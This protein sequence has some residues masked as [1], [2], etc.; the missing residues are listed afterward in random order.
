MDLI[1]ELKGHSGSTV[2]LMRDGGKT[3]VRKIDNVQRNYERLI[4]LNAKLPVPRIYRYDGKI[5]DMEY[6]HGL[7]MKNYLLHHSAK[8]LI[9]FL[10]ESIEWMKRDCISKDYTETYNQ[11]LGFLDKENVFPFTKEELIEKL[12]KVLP[13]SIYHGDM[14]LENIIKSDDG[15]VFIDP[16]TVNY[17]SYVFDIAKLRQ[18]LKCKWFLRHGHLPIDVKLTKIE[19]DIFKTFPEANNDYLL[20]PMLLRVYLHCEKDSVE[21]KFVVNEVSKLWK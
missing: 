8:D 19:N 14:T 13:Q 3:F 2:V 21:Y 9:G 16:V 18:D 4:A 1:K 20:I 11:M 15:F 6:I 7:D 10:V 12:P 5:L 17:D